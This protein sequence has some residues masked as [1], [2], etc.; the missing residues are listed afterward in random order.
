MTHMVSY[1][2]IFIN[3]SNRMQGKELLLTPGRSRDIK[4]NYVS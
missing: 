3:A 4:N 1:G 2:E